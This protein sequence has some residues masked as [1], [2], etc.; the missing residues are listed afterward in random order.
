MTSFRRVSV[1][2]LL[3]AAVAG[4]AVSAPAQTPQPPVPPVPDSVR[5]MLMELQQVQQQLRAIQESTL[6]ANAPLREERAA[7]Q[8]AVESAMREADP[9]VERKIERLEEIAV[10][11]RDARAQQDTARMRRLIEE[12]RR[13]QAEVQRA[14][15]A[16]M[17]REDVVQR[18]ETYRQNLLAAMRAHD[19]RTDELIARLESLARRIHA[20]GPQ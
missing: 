9:D 15:A 14:Q 10:E 4:G 20:A 3:V 16:A 18:I 12:G 8:A 6:E 13:T 19:P 7:A 17:Q 5:E 1:T 2:V 11:L